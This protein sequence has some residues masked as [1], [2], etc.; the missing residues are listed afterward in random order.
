MQFGTSF[1]EAAGRII[2]NICSLILNIE[3][4]A[5]DPFYGTCFK[6]GLIF[7]IHFNA[8][9]RNTITHFS[10]CFNLRVLRSY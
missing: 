3:M 4:Q 1:H 8:C 2:N 9:E 5:N 6:T 10:R 7:G